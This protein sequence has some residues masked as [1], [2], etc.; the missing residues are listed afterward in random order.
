VF[1]GFLPFRKYIDIQLNILHLRG[2]SLSSFPLFLPGAADSE[3]SFG[4]TLLPFHTNGNFCLRPYRDA[5]AKGLDRP[6]VMIQY[7]YLRLTSI[8]D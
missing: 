4:I 1:C 7:I 2:S 8:Q 3:P 5:V 6:H